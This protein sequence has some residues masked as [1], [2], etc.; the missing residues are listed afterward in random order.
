MKT[1]LNSKWP[2]G[3]SGWR[4][5]LLGNMLHI[6]EYLKDSEDERLA[7]W[8]LTVYNASSDL[9]EYYK[10]FNNNNRT[11]THYEDE[12]VKDIVDFA[13]KYVGFDGGET[14]LKELLEDRLNSYRWHVV[15]RAAQIAGS[16]MHEANRQ[17]KL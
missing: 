2:I 7:T 10:T 15:E 13:K 3:S 16:A 1:D 5:T 4:N 9:I 6:G 17:N 12:M 8:G 11:S 14:D